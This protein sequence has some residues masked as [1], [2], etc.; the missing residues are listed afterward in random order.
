[1]RLGE[2]PCGL[3]EGSRAQRAYGKDLVVERHRHRYEYNNDYRNR[4][5]AAG[6]SASG[7]APD[8]SLVEIAEVSGHPFM[9]GSQFHPE[10]VSRPDR[11]HPLFRD[12]IGAATEVLREGGQHSFNVKDEAKEVAAT[13]M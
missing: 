5:E 1:M 4:L 8:G 6:L 3:V 2:Y 7:V 9:L 13:Q 12:F 11:P 10:F